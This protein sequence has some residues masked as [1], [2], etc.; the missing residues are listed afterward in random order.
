MSSKAARPPAL[1]PSPCRLPIRGV[2]D[3]DGLEPYSGLDAGERGH[4]IAQRFTNRPLRGRGVCRALGH[5]LL[6]KNVEGTRTKLK[7]LAKLDILTEVDTGNFAR[8]SWPDTYGR[9]SPATIWCAYW[10]SGPMS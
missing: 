1:R 2:L 7:R 10:S 4:I 5:E 3:H 6:P 9:Q 8:K